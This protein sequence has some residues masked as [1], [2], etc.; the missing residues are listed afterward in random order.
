MTGKI[1]RGP[2]RGFLALS[3]AASSGIT[4]VLMRAGTPSNL[5]ISAAGLL[6]LVSVKKLPMMSQN[7]MLVR[8]AGERTWVIFDVAKWGDFGEKPVNLT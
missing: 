1:A 2:P 8:A 3:M 6:H 4:M 5:A 7:A